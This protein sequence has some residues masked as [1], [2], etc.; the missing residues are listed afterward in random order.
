MWNAL[1]KILADDIELLVTFISASNSRSL[2]AAKKIGMEEITVF[3][4]Q[5]NEFHMLAKKVTTHS[6]RE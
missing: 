2:C 5:G 3:K 1:N 4:F 6:I